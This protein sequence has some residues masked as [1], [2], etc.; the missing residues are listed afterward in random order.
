MRSLPY[1]IAAGM[2][3]LSTATPAIAQT[4]I[5][6]KFSYDLDRTA[7]WNYDQIR[8]TAEDACE[9]RASLTSL[10][11]LHSRTD[12]AECQTDLVNQAVSLLDIDEL[13]TLHTSQPPANTFA[14][15]GIPD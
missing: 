3:A 9:P 13:T 15:A 7:T 4:K 6:A 11:G 1:L 8:K 12:E 10:I 2:L 5:E 14:A